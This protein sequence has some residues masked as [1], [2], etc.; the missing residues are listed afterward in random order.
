MDPEVKEDLL[1]NIRRRLT[2]QPVKFRADIEV[3]CFSYEGIDAIKEGLAAGESYDGEEVIKIKLVAP[4]LYVMITQTPDKN[5]GVKILEDAIERIRGVIEAKGGA[6]VVKLKVCRAS[7]FH[8][9]LSLTLC[10]A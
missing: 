7:C 9:G 1:V 5:T 4:P 3:T 6:I 2:P 10:L 8:H